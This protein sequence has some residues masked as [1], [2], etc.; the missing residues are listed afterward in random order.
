MPFDR[1]EPLHD[2]LLGRLLLVEG[3]EAEVLRSVL[4]HLVHWSD[5]FNY[6][7]KLMEE[8]FEH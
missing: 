8:T 3:D 4:L 6:R 7:P 2:Q 5:D 1:G